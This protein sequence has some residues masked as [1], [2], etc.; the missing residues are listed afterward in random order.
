MHNLLHLTLCLLPLLC[1]SQ[2]SIFDQSA[3]WLHDNSL[4][5]PAEN[6]Q[7]DIKRSTA[8]LINY[9]MVVAMDQH[10]PPIHLPYPA[11]RHAN[12]TFFTVYQPLEVATESYLWGLNNGKKDITL[13]TQRVTHPQGVVDYPKGNQVIPTLNTIVQSWGEQSE[14]DTNQ[15]FINVG[16]L[17]ETIKGIQP[18]TGYLAEFLAFNYRLNRVERTQ[19][20][21][22][23]AIKYAI[24]LQTD[25][26]NSTQQIIWDRTLN[27]SY[28]N[29]ICGIGRDDQ[30]KLQQKQASSSI[31]PNFLTIGFEQIAIS[32]VKNK[33]IVPDQYFVMW[34]DN[35]ADFILEESALVNSDYTVFKRKWLMN[36]SGN[37]PQPLD[38]EVRIDFSKI[39]IPTGYV[40]VLLIDETASNQFDAASV[41]QIKPSAIQDGIVSYKNIKWDIDQSGTDHF[42]F[43]LIKTATPNALSLSPN[44]TNGSFAIAVQLEKAADIQINIFDLHGKLLKQLTGTTNSNYHFTEMIETVGEYFIELTTADYSE[45]KRVVIT[46]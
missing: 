38:T 30:L 21:S 3:I 18:F 13:T 29:K 33:A 14:F 37:T 35:G 25:Y 31:E 1:G 4:E 23:L 27:D 9:N 28:N 22:A 2:S 10:T 44:L 8:T 11:D 6:K 5:M 46:K 26:L 24:P 41:R 34:G 42:T 40:P 39:V 19:I 15:Q 16:N 43:G 36:L 17:D 32:N 20:E 12:F 45:T 7:L